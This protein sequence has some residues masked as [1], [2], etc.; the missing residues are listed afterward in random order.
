MREF[1]K[2]GITLS[3][4][5]SIAAATLAL[6][7]SV[8]AP[9]IEAYE[10]QVV[11][12]SLRDVSGGFNLGSTRESEGDPVV[13]AVYDLTDETGS[14]AGYILQMLATGY[15]GRMTVMAS[16]RLDGEV[17]DAR[18][19]SNSETPGLGKK[20][21]AASYMEKFIG[22]G[23]EYPVPV[24]K[25]DLD[26]SDADSIGGASVTFGGISRAIAYGSDYVKKT[27]GGK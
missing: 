23:S 4:I 20:A 27:L 22:T 15:G 14:R 16:Y 21:E 18:L 3:L 26:K 17:I 9:R 1:A 7:N 19:L 6:V 8:T 24:K 11:Q 25:G 13:T 5:A 12:D 10:T 2:V